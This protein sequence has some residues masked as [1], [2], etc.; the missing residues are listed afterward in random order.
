M[1]RPQL[2]VMAADGH[3]SRLVRPIEQILSAAADDAIL[4]NACEPA[5]L[6]E[7]DPDEALHE[8]REEGPLAVMMSTAAG[9]GPWLRRETQTA[10]PHQLGGPDPEAQAEA[11]LWRS[12]RR[13]DR[14]APITAER[15]GRLLDGLAEPEPA[16]L[17]PLLALVAL[18]QRMREY[19]R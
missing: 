12:A 9:G 11:W 7:S 15:L 19:G 5:N 2:L 18:L 10:L 6:R 17:W 3:I 4:P 1:R 13:V 16:D 8:L 14:E